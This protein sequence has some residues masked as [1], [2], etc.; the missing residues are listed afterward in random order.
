[1]DA[2]NAGDIKQLHIPA[3]ESHKGQNG[4]LLIIGGSHLFHAASLWA[5]TVASRIA[6]L[7]HYSSV[8]ENELVTR[9]KDEF[10]NGIVIKRADIGDYITEDDC[11][12]IGPGMT[13]DRETEALTNTLLA[14][15]RKKLWVIDAGA[16]QMLDLVRIPPG[17]ILTPHRGEF[18]TLW[19][20]Y[21]VSLLRRD[22]LLHKR[23]GG[24]VG[25]QASDKR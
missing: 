23:F 12:L 13:R 20:K 8:P 7:V 11:I 17:A 19:Q 24:Q 5:L 16:L 6:D 18:A 1:M 3:A 15:H 25:G 22:F 10:R 21:Q 14:N 4:K 9:A 2:V